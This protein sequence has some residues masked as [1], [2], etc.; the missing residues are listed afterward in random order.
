LGE[1]KSEVTEVLRFDEYPGV[2]QLQAF[3]ALKSL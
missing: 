3:V 2:I 1:P